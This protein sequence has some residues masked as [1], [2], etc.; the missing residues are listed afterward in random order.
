LTTVGP[1]PF[2][3]RRASFSGSEN[4]IDCF[5]LRGNGVGRY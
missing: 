2:T 1:T 5:I 3:A 4:F